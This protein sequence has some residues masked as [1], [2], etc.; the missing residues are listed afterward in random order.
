[1]I[2]GLTVTFAGILQAGAGG[3]LTVVV[4]MVLT[5][6]LVSRKTHEERVNDAKESAATWRA[7][8]EASETARRETESIARDSLETS[9]AVLHL[10]HTLRSVAF[11]EGKDDAADSPNG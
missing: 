3:I 10:M 1:M 11:I 2:D 6:K 7:A 4:F 8:H 9:R 5:G